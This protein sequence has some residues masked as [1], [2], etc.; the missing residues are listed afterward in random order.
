MWFYF[1][2]TAHIKIDFQMSSIYPSAKSMYQ[3][4][5][6][7]CSCWIYE[8][9][10]FRVLCSTPKDSNIKTAEVLIL[11]LWI[12]DPFIEVQLISVAS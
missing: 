10:L 3:H 11:N 8:L 12:I 2:I 9:L 1:F 7:S 4:I 5:L 6:V